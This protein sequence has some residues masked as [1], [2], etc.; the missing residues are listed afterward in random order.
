MR[1]LIIRMMIGS[2]LMLVLS[3]GAFAGRV[4]ATDG[5]RGD[6]CTV[7]ADEIILDDFYFF[8]NS[9][10]VHGYIDGD[11]V[12]I[13][14]EVTIAR[15]GHVTGD[16]WMLGGQLVIEGTIGEDVHF[17]GADLDITGLSRFPNPESD[18]VAGGIS[19]EVSRQAIIPNDVIYYGYQAILEGRVNGN[20]DFQGQALV[21]H[22]TIGGNVNA[23]VA[24]QEGNRPL[25]NLP[26][27]YSVNVRQPGLYFRYGSSRT[28]GY[29]NGDLNYE[30]PERTQARPN[31]GGRIIYTQSVERGS[32]QE[33][34]EARTAL[35]IMGN[36]ILETIRDIAALALVGVLT[37]NFFPPV[38]TEPGYRVQR[39]SI[40]AFSLGIMLALIFIPVAA[41]L[42]IA[43]SLL[44]LVLTFIITLNELTILV[45]VFLVVVNL[46]FLGVAF[47]LLWFLGRV[48]ASFVIGF[49]ILR[50]TQK[51]WLRYDPNPPN[52]LGEVWLAIVVGITFG[53]LVVNM[54]LGP[55]IG[56]LQF[57]LNG[58]M[59]CAGLGA[60][61][62]YL[63]DLYYQSS[64]LFVTPEGDW[65]SIPPPPEDANDDMDTPL[66]MNN[67]P[68]GFRG[69]DD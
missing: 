10:V 8:C 1:R 47:F 18:I 40:T 48:I 17:G 31:V 52:L 56:R 63:R 13:G 37:M 14:S 59:A 66:G 41:L 32:L 23:S 42:L 6:S 11:L 28:E 50:L 38:V 16:V 12:G 4:E 43:S 33:A 64:G 21:I 25:S 35:Q 65:R 51:V 24:D 9:L 26:L 30:A 34:E 19:M 20:V 61:F 53:S 54:P 62:M 45:G 36:Y 7:G 15:E 3:L 29:V 5:L 46:G 68:P 57:L 69:F 39:K 60:L 2:V 22:N 44:L 67:L 58:V 55:F 27:F 49:F